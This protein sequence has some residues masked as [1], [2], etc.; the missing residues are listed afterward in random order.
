MSGGAPATSG[1]DVAA[2]QRMQQTGGRGI[3]DSNAERVGALS[4]VDELEGT[5]HRGWNIEA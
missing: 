5:R 2:G 1:G 4:G 3:E